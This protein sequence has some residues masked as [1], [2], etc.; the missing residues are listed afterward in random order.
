MFSN[1]STP[2]L[3][4]TMYDGQYLYP[5]YSCD[6]L[7]APPSYYTHCKSEPNVACHSNQYMMLN[8]VEQLERHSFLSNSLNLIGN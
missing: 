2:F 5:S 4:P 6:Q 3:S 8:T 7:L 1:Q